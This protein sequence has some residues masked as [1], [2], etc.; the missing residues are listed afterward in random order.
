MSKATKKLYY[1]IYSYFY[2]SVKGPHILVS[3]R[4]PEI[5]GPALSAMSLLCWNCRRIGK[6][7]TVRELRDLARQFAPSI[8]CILETQ[9]EG[10]R[11]ENM[12][13][14]LGYNKSFAV[15]SSGRS[16]GLCVF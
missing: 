4:A 7:A 15:S 2:V 11:V 6:A 1:Y 12:A 10:M 13:D 9:I 16:G 14:G 8:L 5:S 3:P